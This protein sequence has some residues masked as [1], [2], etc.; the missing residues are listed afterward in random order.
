MRSIPSLQYP[1][2]HRKQLA[3]P[4]VQQLRLHFLQDVRPSLARLRSNS[5]S[6][7][8]PAITNQDLQDL[9]DVRPSLARLRSNSTSDGAPAITNQDLGLVLGCGVRNHRNRH[10]LILIR[11]NLQILRKDLHLVPVLT[12]NGQVSRIGRVK[13]NSSR[14]RGILTLPQHRAVNCAPPGG[15]A[16][17]ITLIPRVSRNSATGTK[18]R[19]DETS[20]AMS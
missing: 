7:G 4:P 11:C 19:S 12:G 2:T 15:K 5:T 8:A 6:D 13:R 17:W 16:P 3:V 9:Q 18:S 20:T 10:S 1:L 14:R